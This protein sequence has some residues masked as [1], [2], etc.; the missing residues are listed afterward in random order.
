MK[1]SDD[2]VRRNTYLLLVSFWVIALG[3]A[4]A[5]YQYNRN[6][7]AAIEREERVQLAAIA[8]LRVLQ[9]QEWRKE[10]LGD[11]RVL[12]ASSLPAAASEFLAGARI[13]ESRRREI[14][15]WLE[16]I[17]SASGNVILKPD[18]AQMDRRRREH[19]RPG[20]LLQPRQPSHAKQ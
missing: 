3:V 19:T 5:G 2:P 10:R 18:T 1:S 14:N 9:I 20:E 17:R 13:S 11:A 7:R 6:Q 16:T 8:D 15:D 12:M 4:F